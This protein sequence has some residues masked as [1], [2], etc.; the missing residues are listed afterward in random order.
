MDQRLFHLAAWQVSSR[1]FIRSSLANFAPVVTAPIA[2]LAI[3]APIDW[4]LALRERETGNAGPAQSLDSSA[5]I[6]PPIA[7]SRGRFLIL[8][9]SRKSI[10]S[11]GE[12]EQ[13]KDVLA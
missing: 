8:G 3:S 6:V 12:V 1:P 2:R 4:W 10:L 5:K 9:S 11:I 13:M 7:M